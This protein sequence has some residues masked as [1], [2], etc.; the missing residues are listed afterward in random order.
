MRDDRTYQ[1]EP[2]MPQTPTGIVGEFIEYARSIGVNVRVEK[3]D[4]PDTFDKI[5]G[6][7]TESK[8]SEW[9]K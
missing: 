7:T 2:Y 1:T 4:V 5:F 9:M 3:S 6:F 8:V